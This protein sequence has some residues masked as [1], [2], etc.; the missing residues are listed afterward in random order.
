M[1]PSNVTARCLRERKE[2]RCL[3]KAVYVVLMAALFTTAKRERD[4]PSADE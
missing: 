3:Q 4:G 2:Y 1:R